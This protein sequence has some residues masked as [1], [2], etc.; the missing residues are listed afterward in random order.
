MS[1]LCNFARSRLVLAS[2]SEE[3]TEEIITRAHELTNLLKLPSVAQFVLAPAAL[4][5]S[6][7]WHRDTNASLPRAMRTISGL[8]HKQSSFQQS[9]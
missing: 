7:R 2:Y 5:E 1:K 8:L 4:G 6:P 3:D 9:G